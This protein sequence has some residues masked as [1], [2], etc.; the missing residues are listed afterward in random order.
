MRENIRL[1]KVLIKLRLERVMMFRLGFFGP[2]FVDG[3]LFVIQLL[4]FQAIYSNVDRIGNWKQ[5]DMILFIGTFSLINALNMSIYF[6]G[7]N[8]IPEKIRTG[9]IDLYLT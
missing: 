5:G 1:I 4:V 3:S 6:F 9:E 2:F 8:S 7:V